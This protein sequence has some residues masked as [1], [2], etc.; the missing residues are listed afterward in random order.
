MWYAGFPVRLSGGHLLSSMSALHSAMF[1]GGP[2]RSLSH[3]RVSIELQDASDSM[4]ADVRSRFFMQHEIQRMCQPAR[5][6]CSNS[7]GYGS[8]RRKRRFGFTHSGYRV[9]IPGCKWVT[10]SAHW[11]S[12][13]DNFG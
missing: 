2:W 5:F 8:V 3:D 7:N 12:R 6:S 13:G 9:A 1:A 10:N 4:I 11:E